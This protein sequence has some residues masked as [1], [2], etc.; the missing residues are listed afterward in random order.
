MTDTF[1]ERDLRA[2]FQDRAGG[3]AS[4]DLFDRI[5]QEVAATRQVRRLVAL[6]G[7]NIGVSMRQLGWAAVIGTSTLALVGSMLV[8]GGA[9]SVSVNPTQPPSASPSVP[10][11]RSVVLRPDTVAVVLAAEGLVI[12]SRPDGRDGTERLPRGTRLFVV[13]GPTTVNGTDWYQVK[14]FLDEGPFGWVPAARAG[15]AVVEPDALECPSGA[16]NPKAVLATGATHALACFGNRTIE[17]RGHIACDMDHVVYDVS[18]P[19][20]LETERFCRFKDADDEPLVQLFG[21]PWDEL[22][23]DWRTAEMAVQGHLDDPLAKD[24]VSPPA[25]PLTKD[26][27]VLL[28][29]GFFVVS[30]VSAAG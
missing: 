3:A 15:Q 24:C 18:G 17:M 9:P 2:A 6:P 1:S 30:K 12:E 27:A 22:P 13:A 10:L 16:L 7:L 14:A 8:G 25:G 26:E 11:V 19:F 20:W 28:C 4:S 5:E 29:R 23:P 21:M